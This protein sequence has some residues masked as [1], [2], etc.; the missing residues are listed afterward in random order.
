MVTEVHQGLPWQL[1]GHEDA[2]SLLLGLPARALLISGPEGVGRRQ[3]ARW[4]SA[5]LNCQEVTATGGPCGSC[6]SCVLWQGGHPDHTEI[7][8]QLVTGSG[9]LN[10]R[11]EIRI[12]QLVERQGQDEEPLSTWLE[13]RPLF[14]WRVGVIDSAHLL[15]VAAANSFLK[16]LEEP[17]SWARLILIAPDRLSLL[18]TIASRVTALRL[19]TVDTAGWE[20]ADH[21]AHLLGTPGPLLQAAAQ[22]EQWEEAAAAV[23][24]FFSALSGPLTAAL[25]AAADLEKLWLAP[26]GSDLPQLLRAGFRRFSPA[27][28]VA[29]E[30]ALRDCEELLA[31]FVSPAVALQLF[32]LDLRAAADRG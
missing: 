6:S 14:R 13:R 8:P 32:T 5:A 10:R 16:M 9:R 11:P 26:G 18:P 1:L 22:P 30:D 29:A 7:A 4:Y 3:L 19:A 15:T 24:G 2:R 25:A 20:P 12:G 17:P 28:R 23:D 21:P 31:A 27:A